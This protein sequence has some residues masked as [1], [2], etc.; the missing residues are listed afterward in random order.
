[1]LLTPPIIETERL[2]LRGHRLDD[3]ADC[4]A[5]W[6][7]PAVT[8][9]IGGKASTAQQVWS[10]ILNYAGHWTLMN[11][12]YWAVEEKASRRFVGELGFANFKRDIE[13]EMRDAPELGWAFASPFH[14]KGF[15][16]EAARAAVSWGDERFASARTVCLI[17]AEN[18]PSIRV[19]QKCGYS[20]FRRTRFNDQPTLFFER[21]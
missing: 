5:M 17:N 15:A 21:Y 8:R 18:L 3:F 11:F 12:G 7:D 2:T 10:R 14:G 19:A 9:F 4:L 16:T 1:M 6:S 20:E 13:P